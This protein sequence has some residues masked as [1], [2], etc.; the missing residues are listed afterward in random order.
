M[1]EYLKNNT[2]LTPIDSFDYVDEAEG[3]EEMRS[4]SLLQGTTRI[5]FGL[6]YKWLNHAGRAELPPERE[7]LFNHHIRAAVKFVDGEL[8]D[9]TI[10]GPSQK[11]PNF[12]ELNAKCPQSEWKE[13]FGKLRG[14]WSGQIII[15]LIDPITLDQYAWVA[16]LETNGAMMAVNDLLKRIKLKQLL[17]R[18]PVVPILRLG[19]TTMPSKKYGPRPR[20]HFILGEQWIDRGDAVQALP[21]PIAPALPSPTESQSQPVAGPDQ[22]KPAPMQM[23]TAA[24]QMQV[25]EPQLKTVETPSLKEDLGDEIAF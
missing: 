16:K 23:Q 25:I 20:P 5:E 2:S 6:N 15:Y 12:A 22:A 4:H 3:E 24:A 9:Q 8:A 13:A 7:Y 17:C 21:A 14:P 11:F 19:T 1:T 10:L 18:A